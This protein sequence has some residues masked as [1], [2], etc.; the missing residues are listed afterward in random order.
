MNKKFIFA[1]IGSSS[2]NQETIQ[3]MDKSGVDIFRINLSHTEVH[4]F[5]EIRS[6]LTYPDRGTSWH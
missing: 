1:T 6:Q 3:K 2:T 5:R 4:E